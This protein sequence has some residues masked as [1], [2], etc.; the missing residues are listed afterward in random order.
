MSI[1][2]AVM[3]LAWYSW[4]GFDISTS[5]SGQLSVN[6]SQRTDLNNGVVRVEYE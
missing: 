3:V 6:R 4:N 1:A 5:K 2:A